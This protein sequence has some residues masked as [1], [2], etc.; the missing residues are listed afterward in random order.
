MFIRKLG[1]IL[2]GSATPFQLSAACILGAMLG[3]V[4]GLY[5]APGPLVLLTL[6]LILLNAN[7]GVAVMAG[8]VAKLLSLVLMP[9][10]FSVGRAILD[11]PLQSLAKAAINAPVLALFGF[12]YYLTTGGILVGLIVGLVFALG[13]VKGIGAF[14]KKM[15]SLEEESE[16]YKALIS[17]KWV[18]AC[19]FVLVGGGHGKK[20]YQEMMEV[21]IG[22]AIR[23]LGVVFV[24]VVLA[25][26]FVLRMFA[27][28]DIILLALQRGLENAN[29]ATVDIDRAELDLGEGRLTVAGL[30]MAD[31]DDLGRDIF[32][33]ALVE[34]NLSATDLLRKRIRVE[35][36]RISEASHGEERIAPGRRLGTGPPQPEPSDE[37]EG[38]GK[39]LEDLLRNAKE[40]KE[41]LEKVREWLEKISSPEGPE[42]GP[43]GEEGLAERL[44]REIRELGYRRVAASHLVEGSPTVLVSKLTVEKLRVPGMAEETFHIQAENLS[45]HPRL[46]PGPPRLAVK[47]DSLAIDLDFSEAAGKGDNSIQ[48]VSKSIPME[49]A[50]GQLGDPGNVP[51][52]GGTIDLSAEGKFSATGRGSINLPV[53]AVIQGATVSL[54]EGQEVKVDRLELAF[55]IHGSFANPRV[56]IDYQ[57]V[58]EALKEAGKQALKQKL[59]EEAGKVADKLK[60]QLKDKLGEEEAEELK[61]K[62]EDTLGK[63]K[64]EDLKKKGKGLLDGFLGGKKK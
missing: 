10:T 25:F 60:D 48:L 14:R 22:K 45:T 42:G 40:W 16:T 59:G 9:L 30:A 5:Q 53:N 13:L 32:R 47:S 20:T 27:Q 2:R 4:P 64:T 12:E 24:A 33:A 63:E 49:R 50:L 17:K 39:S 43:A 6:L 57:Q 8:A 37:P 41:K 34:G 58:T 36:V 15:A 21:K 55:E 46:A 54:I 26:L 38:D 51:L 28:D 35:H 31:P 61:G 52:K 19:L 18:K 44:E 23:P 1:K 3:F 29:G 11:G 56:R 7:F 62:L